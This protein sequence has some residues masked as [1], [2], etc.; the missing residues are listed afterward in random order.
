MTKLQTGCNRSTSALR[1]MLASAVVADLYTPM[2][3][4]CERYLLAAAHESTSLPLKIRSPH[5]FPDLRNICPSTAAFSR[6]LSTHLC[7]P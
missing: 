1:R 7:S 6:M 4:P 5:P 3:W 2:W